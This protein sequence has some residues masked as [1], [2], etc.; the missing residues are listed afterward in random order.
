MTFAHISIRR[1]AVR[2]ALTAGLTAALAAGGPAVASDGT[3]P[4]SPAPTAGA[5]DKAAPGKAA[6]GKAAP[7]KL[8]AADA[9]ALAKA[10]A[11]GARNVT[12][13][14]AAKPGDTARTAARRGGRGGRTHPTVRPGGW[15][16]EAG[17][18]VGGEPPG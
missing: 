9:A 7:D 15:E 5:P 18:G 3:G 12:F 11:D 1:R 2:V 6:A 8:G 13:M 16:R 10:E 14:V 4:G 17:K